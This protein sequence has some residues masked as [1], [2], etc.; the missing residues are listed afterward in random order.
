MTEST[1]RFVPRQPFPLVGDHVWNRRQM[2]R[3]VSYR[4]RI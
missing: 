3:A 4:I 1:L 2:A